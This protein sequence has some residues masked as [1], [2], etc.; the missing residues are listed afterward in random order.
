MEQRSFTIDA[1]QIRRYD[2]MVIFTWQK[3]AVERIY[4]IN[5]SELTMWKTSLGGQHEH[6]L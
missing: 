6:A 2:I 1:R 5:S 4:W 3:K